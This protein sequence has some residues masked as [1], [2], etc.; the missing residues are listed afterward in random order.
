MARGTVIP[1]FEA[2]Q[3]GEAPQQLPHRSHAPGEGEGQDD[4]A[5]AGALCAVPSPVHQACHLPVGRPVQLSE[6]GRQKVSIGQNLGDC[7][8]GR[9]IKGRGTEVYPNNYIKQ[10]YQSCF[11]LPSSHHVS[12]SKPSQGKYFHVRCLIAIQLPTYTPAL[13]PMQQS[14]DFCDGA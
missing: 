3:V 10:C 5:V 7:G 2:L 4:R 8:A 14:C 13:A 1:D 11:I 6:D 9:L 12:S